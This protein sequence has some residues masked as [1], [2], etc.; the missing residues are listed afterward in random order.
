MKNKQN[1]RKPIHLDSFI[2][3]VSH[4]IKMINLQELPDFIPFEPD[5]VSQKEAVQIQEEDME[6]SNFI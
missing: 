6:V 3:S 5:Q 2:L 1:F 4:F